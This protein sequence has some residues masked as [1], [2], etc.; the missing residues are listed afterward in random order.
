C[1]PWES[2]RVGN[3]GLFARR[4]VCTLLCVRTCM[5]H[6]HRRD[7]L[8]SDF[9]LS[10]SP[11]PWK[12]PLNGG[13][14]WSAR[15]RAATCRALPLSAASLYLTRSRPFTR[16]SRHSAVLGELLSALPRHPLPALALLQ[17]Q[18]R[19]SSAA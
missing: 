18:C 19:V 7:R 10:R 14:A 6:T 3:G 13:N 4:C 12:R 16:P 2:R 8:R 17:L 1:V 5:T 9:L 15:R 11:S